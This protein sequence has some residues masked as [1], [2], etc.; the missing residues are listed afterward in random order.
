MN[1]AA[2]LGDVTTY[3]GDGVLIETRLLSIYD[4][5]LPRL[6]RAILD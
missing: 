4:G 6:D 2:F 1:E 5:T 3:F